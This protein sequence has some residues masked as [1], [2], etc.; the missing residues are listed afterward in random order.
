MKSLLLIKQKLATIVNII[1]S[2]FLFFKAS[3]YLI[4]NFNYKIFLF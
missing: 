3:T 2:F 4:Y 1:K